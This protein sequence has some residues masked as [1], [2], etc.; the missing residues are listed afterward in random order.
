MHTNVFRG[1]ALRVATYSQGAKKVP[2]AVFVPLL[3]T[4]M[5]RRLQDRRGKGKEGEFKSYR[6]LR[7][8]S[9]VGTMPCEPEGGSEAVRFLFP[10]SFQSQT[11]LLPEVRAA[12]L[13]LV[14]RTPGPPC[15][16]LPMVQDPLTDRGQR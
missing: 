12:Q 7:Q 14:R 1:E 5:F 4:G 9:G 10:K 2:A 6:S 16:L 11:A 15:T 3:S 8:G 13:P